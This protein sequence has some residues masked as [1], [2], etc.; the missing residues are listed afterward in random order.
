M[1][2]AQEDPGHAEAYVDVLGGTQ[3]DLLQELVDSA[4]EHVR[5]VDQIAG[6]ILKARIYAWRKDNRMSGKPPLVSTHVD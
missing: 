3:D 2:H 5:V 6:R 4:V 1:P